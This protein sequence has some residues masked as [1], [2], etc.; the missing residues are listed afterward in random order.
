MAAST[1]PPDSDDPHSPDLHIELGL[2]A[3]IVTVREQQ[4][5][6]LV[7]RPG[8]VGSGEFDALPFGPFSPREHRTLEIGLRSWVEEQTGLDLGYVEQLYTFGD[9]GRH[10]EA[11]QAVSHMLSVGY[12]AL[13]RG[14]VEDLRGSHWSPGMPISPGKTGGRASRRSSPMRSSRV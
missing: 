5:Q 11:A 9:R 12:L 4:P 14:T 7:V 8:A 3:A 6:I 10:A 2:N 13:T 1:P